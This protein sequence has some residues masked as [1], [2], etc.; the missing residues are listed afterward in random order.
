MPDDR[1]SEGVVTRV[2]IAALAQLFDT[3]EFAFD[4]RATA[5]REAESEFEERVRRVFEERVQPSY[6]GV[7]FATFHCR[8]KSLCREYL[9]KNAP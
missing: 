3:F 7:S 8:L 4:P 1:L 6:P 2:E 9:R 5:A